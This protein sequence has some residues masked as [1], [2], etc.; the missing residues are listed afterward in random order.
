M[1]PLLKMKM[2]Y[3]NHFAAEKK[4]HFHG[5]TAKRLEKVL[6]FVLNDKEFWEDVLLRHGGDAM[7]PREMKANSEFNYDHCMGNMAGMTYKIMLDN[8]IIKP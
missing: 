4:Y 6:P 3:W 5:M 2:Q 1:N 7:T 8:K